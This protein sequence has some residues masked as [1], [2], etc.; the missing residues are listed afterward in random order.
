MCEGERGRGHVPEGECA[1]D[2]MDETMPIEVHSVLFKEKERIK[3]GIR[4]HGWTND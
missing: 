2:G 3:K 1:S 4:F